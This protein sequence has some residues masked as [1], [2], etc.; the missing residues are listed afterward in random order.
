MT[1]RAP[2]HHCR[3]PHLPH[4]AEAAALLGGA[5]R[6]VAQVAAQVMAG[7]VAKE[8]ATAA[9]VGPPVLVSTA[10]LVVVVTALLVA[11]LTQQAAVGGH[12]PPGFLQS[13]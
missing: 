4:V 11:G 8:V 13:H 9:T 10:F 1:T 12:W 2:T 7:V 3:R 5:G 6:V